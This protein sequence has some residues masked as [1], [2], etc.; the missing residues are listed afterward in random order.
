MDPML[1]VIFTRALERLLIVAVGALA[2]F[3]GFRLFVLMP[4]R[5]EGESKLDL[6]GGVSIVLSRVGPGIFFALFGTGLIAYS[7]SP[8]SFKLPEQVASAAN[9]ATVQTAVAHYLGMIDRAGSASAGGTLPEASVPRG[10]VVKALNAW[11]AKAA[12]LPTGERLDAQ[13][14][15]REAKLS[16]MREIWDSAKWGD[17]AAFHRWIVVSAE[18]GAPPDGSSVAVDFYRLE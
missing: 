11:A 2:I 12:D 17:Y 3:I 1:A 14:A 18:T 6:P 8:V 7:A 9:E 5:K 13:M 15:V 10:T 16:L 4:L